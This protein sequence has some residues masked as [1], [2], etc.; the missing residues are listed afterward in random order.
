MRVSGVGV[1][2]VL[3]MWVHGSMWGASS[4]IEGKHTLVGRI[5]AS[6]QWLIGSMG[7]SPDL[8]MER[9]H[10]IFYRWLPEA[11]LIMMVE[12]VCPCAK[13][14]WS[15]YMSSWASKLGFSSILYLH[16]NRGHVHVEPSYLNQNH[17][18]LAY[19][20]LYVTLLWRWPTK[21]LTKSSSTAGLAWFED[22]FGE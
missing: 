22:L 13:L 4:T 7:R 10:P 15:G 1:F 20:L 5:L 6:L 8:H 21:M 16:S 14:G 18:W 19:V 17:S 9:N 12:L 3:F 2:I 11:L